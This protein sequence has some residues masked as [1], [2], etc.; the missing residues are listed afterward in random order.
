MAWIGGNRYLSHSE[1]ENN[2]TIVWNY[3]G[4]KSWTL[5]AVSAILG[6]MQSESTINPNIWESLTVNY[7][8]GYGLVQWTPATKYI[9]WAGADWESGDKELDRIIYEVDNGLQW[10]SNPNA[11]IVNPPITFKEFTTSTEPPATLANYFL[12]YYEHP[13]VTIQPI[14]AEQ[15]NAWYEYLSGKPPEPPEPPEPTGKQGKLPVWAYC[16]LF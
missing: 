2:A 4:S 13:A 9:N 16:R 14:R 10:F 7:S 12:W 6:N 11:P 1:M 15:A 8:R 3:L 5:N